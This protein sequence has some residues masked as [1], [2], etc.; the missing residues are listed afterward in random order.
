MVHRRNFI[1][2]TGLALV[3]CSIA[4]SFSFSTKEKLAIGIQ[5]YSLRETIADNP[6][7]ILKKLANVGF[8][9][10]ETY[11][12]NDG[13]FWGISIAELKEELTK[14]NLISPSGHY[15]G[16]SLIKGD[17]ENFKEIIS[18]ANQLGQEYIIIPSIE[19]NLR[20]SKSDYQNIAEKFNQAGEMCK[21]GRNHPSLS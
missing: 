8:N 1:K 7:E 9:E 16:N 12:Y 21:V 4:P 5:L 15:D 18:V 11:G 14:N 3:A 10:I 19:E 20:E 2:Q 6:M 13:K 17:F